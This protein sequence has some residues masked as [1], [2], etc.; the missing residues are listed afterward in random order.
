MKGL[1]RS[2]TYCRVFKPDWADPL[3]TSPSKLFGGRW[4]APGS[5]GALY[6]NRDT[7]VAAANCRAQHAG[8]AIGLFD[9]QPDR[10]PRLL[11]VDVPDSPCLD[12]VS[13]SGI[14][15]L[16]LPAAFPL[17]VDHNR[18]RP[19]GLR[20]YR[21]GRFRGIACR[22]AAECR[23][24]YWVGEEL[25]WFDSSPVLRENGPRQDFASW[26]PDPIP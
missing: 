19:I 6:L 2:G 5:F 15:E 13:P 12:V 14:E 8:R 1:R 21:D 20:A 22:S 23:A 9:L 3:D 25:A 10:R 11:R 4:N 17:G 18:C 7:T 24:M 26:Y 16:R